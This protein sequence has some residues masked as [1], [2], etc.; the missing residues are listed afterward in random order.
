[1]T[2]TL[3]AIGAPTSTRRRN[4]IPNPSFEVSGANWVATGGTAT[5]TTTFPQMW[6]GTGSGAALMQVGADGSNAYLTLSQTSATAAPVTPGQWVAVALLVA[7]E[8]TYPAEGGGIRAD[9]VCTGTATTY[10]ASGP[11][12]PAPFYAGRRILW[13]FQ[14][15]STA[16][17]AYVRVQAYSG[18]TATV[19]PAGHRMWADSVVMT[20]VGTQ[21]EALAAIDTYFDGDTTDPAG[22]LTYAWDDTPG[23]STSRELEP[24]GALTPDL[25]LDYVHE[26]NTG[27][28]VYWPYTMDIDTGPVIARRSAAYTSGTL[29]LFCKTQQLALDV[30]RLCDGT[31][32]VR[33]VS[34]EVPYAPYTFTPTGAVRTTWNVGYDSWVVSVPYQRLTA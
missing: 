22:L 25:V 5:R 11:F 19:L 14:A 7:G 4:L 28:T 30:G 3:Y 13:A 20:V 10:H 12:T 34:D 8:T 31:T 21:A 26:Q 18:A 24:D 27:V 2:T 9:V 32:S 23:L 29:E 1:M 15:P 6:G 33:L 16:T 17:A